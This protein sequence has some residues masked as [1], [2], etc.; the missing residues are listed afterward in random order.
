MLALLPNLAY[1]SWVT[2]G[3]DGPASSANG[4]V[5]ASLLAG[6]WDDDFEAGNSF[7]VDDNQGSGWYLL[8][9]TASNSQAEMT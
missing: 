6:T 1:D 2:I 5:N 3:L 9:P 7:V 4:E 8:P